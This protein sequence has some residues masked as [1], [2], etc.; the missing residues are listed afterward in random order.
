[1]ANG[2][3]SSFFPCA[4]IY[5][6]TGLDPRSATFPYF[7]NDMFL[8]N[9]L[10]NLLFVDDTT[11][12]QKGSNISEIGSFINDEL[13]KLGM[14]LRANTLAVNVSK[15]KIMVSIQKAKSSNILTFCLIAMMLELMI[16][17]P[18]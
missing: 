14:W 8:S 2:T 17:I 7:F 18:L 3:L 6:T 11:G 13:Q 9:K 12:L 4:R 1:M 10:F 16:R 5:S 15:T